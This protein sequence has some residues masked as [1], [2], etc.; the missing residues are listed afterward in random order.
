MTLKKFGLPLVGLALIA[1]AVLSVPARAQDGDD[2]GLWLV[3][4]YIAAG[5]LLYVLL[6]DD[7]DE[8]VSP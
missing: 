5:G 3:A 1:S 7:K 6:D 8:P 4:G 2:E